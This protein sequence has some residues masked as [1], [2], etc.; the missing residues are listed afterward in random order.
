MVR[1]GAD[2]EAEGVEGYVCSKVSLPLFGT[3]GQLAIMSI[4][5]KCFLVLTKSGYRRAF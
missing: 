4:F 2:D 1:T 5:M 3:V